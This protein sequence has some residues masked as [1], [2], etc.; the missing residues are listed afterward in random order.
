MKTNNLLATRSRPRHSNDNPFVEQKNG[1]IVRKDAF[2]YRY[3]TPRELAVLKALW[4]LVNVRKNLFTPTTKAVG[5]KISR[6]GRQVRAYDAPCTPADRVRLTGVMLP[7]QRE[8][9]DQLYWDTDLAELT[10]RIHQLQQELIRLAEA[11]TQAQVQ[12]QVS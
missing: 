1:D 11:K 8:A 7:P 3:D 10:R 12:A 9:L 6:S 4:P 2:Y 5:Y